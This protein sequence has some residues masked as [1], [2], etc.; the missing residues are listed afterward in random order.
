MLES[1]TIT[2]IKYSIL[3]FR[4]ANSGMIGFSH[5]P[6]IIWS[7][8]V[9]DLAGTGTSMWF[10]FHKPALR[11]YHSAGD[12]YVVPDIQKLEKEE[13]CSSFPVY[14]Q[15]I[16]VSKSQFSQA[17][18]RAPSSNRLAVWRLQQVANMDTGEPAADSGE[19]ED[20]H[21]E[22]G[23]NPSEGMPES[24]T[25]LRAPE[26]LKRTRGRPKG[27]RNKIQRSQSP[28]ASTPKAY[29]GWSKSTTLTFVGLS[30]N[31]RRDTTDHVTVLV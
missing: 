18:A 23:D 4:A 21:D 27:S 5:P 24:Q 13:N 15:S 3:D 19:W 30:A 12:S 7:I 28:Q 26:I 10:N 22:N 2:Y 14:H 1:W 9:S 31:W 16:T 29:P 8:R 20:Q 25:I 6:K 11:L 17:A